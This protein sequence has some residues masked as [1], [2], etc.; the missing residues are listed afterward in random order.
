MDNKKEAVLLLTNAQL[1][2][3]KEQTARQTKWI[4]NG[5]WVLLIVLGC[6]FLMHKC[7]VP[8]KQRPP[9]P[10]DVRVSDGTALIN[11]TIR[12]VQRNIYDINDDG[13]IDCIDHATLFHIA[14]GSASRII[15]NKNKD[16]GMNH[17]FNK[18]TDR[19]NNRTYYLEP[20]TS[21]PDRWQMDTNWGR[22]YNPQYNVDE[23]EIWMRE[24]TVWPSWLD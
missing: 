2:A 15:H 17:L 14:Y 9:Q 5:V 22:V 8:P 10:R 21:D 3:Q 1:E 12:L 16:T 13:L 19:T 4:T 23:T 20:W 11:E 18:V 24:V 7:K 6:G